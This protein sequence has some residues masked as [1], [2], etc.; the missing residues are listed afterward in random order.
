MSSDQANI[1]EN[2]LN[3]EV[4]DDSN[5]L[6]IKNRG[7]FFQKNQNIL[8]SLAFMRT[9]DEISQWVLINSNGLKF[10]ANPINASDIDRDNCLTAVQ[11]PVA[12]TLQNI[13]ERRKNGRDKRLIEANKAGNYA[14]I[15]DILASSAASYW[16]DHGFLNSSKNLKIV[17]CLKNYERNIEKKD[18]QNAQ[19][20]HIGAIVDFKKARK[21]GAFQ[22]VL[23]F[24]ET[25]E[26]LRLENE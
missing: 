15:S 10:I 24:F 17:S 4:K 11:L 3:P 12:L 2:L 19:I 7:D 14:L 1:I 13:E 22:E 5:I 16:R 9:F 25:E 26:I 18:F 8:E 20:N 23:D 21:K 6:E